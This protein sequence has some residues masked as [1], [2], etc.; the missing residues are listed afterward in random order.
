MCIFVHLTEGKFTL[1]FPFK[2]VFQLLVLLGMDV[3]LVVTPVLSS[4]LN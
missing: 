3:K 1:L 2:T 4:K